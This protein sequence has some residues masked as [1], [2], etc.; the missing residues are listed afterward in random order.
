MIIL[1]IKAVKELV[2]GGAKTGTSP[3]DFIAVAARFGSKLAGWTLG[4]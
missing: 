4:E 3:V 1:E 2:P